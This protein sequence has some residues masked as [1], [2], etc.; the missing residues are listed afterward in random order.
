ME[1]VKNMLSSLDW[2]EYLLYYLIIVNIFSF[3]LFT[4]DRIRHNL[5]GKTIKPLWLYGFVTIFGG[6]LGVNLDFPIE[7]Y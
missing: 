3:F 2:K 7:T 4:I 6:A 5:T 1:N